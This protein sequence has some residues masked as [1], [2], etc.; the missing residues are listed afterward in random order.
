M[1]DFSL[2]PSS[3]L[4]DQETQLARLQGNVQD[5]LKPAPNAPKPI[6]PDLFANYATHQKVAMEAQLN[7][8]SYD[9]NQQISQS[10]SAAFGQDPQVTADMT[11]YAKELDIP[12]EQA[13]QNP[14]LTRRAY[15]QSLLRAKDLATNYPVVAKLMQSQNFAAQT[16]DDLDNLIYH[17]DVFSYMKRQVMSGLQQQEKGRLGMEWVMDGGGMMSPDLKAK[18][19]RIDRALDLAESEKGTLGGFLNVVGQ[20]IGTVPGTVAAGLVGSLGTP[21]AGAAASFSATL[22]QVGYTQM[23]TAYL[24][25]RARGVPHDVAVVGAFGSGLAEGLLEATGEQI[26]AAPLKAII[27]AKAAA[28][29]S[30]ALTKKTTLKALRT[31]AIDT[32]KGGAGEVGTETMQTITERMAD[33]WADTH[34]G[35]DIKKMAELEDGR[36]KL[37]DAL[38]DTIIQTVESIGPMAVFFPMLRVN[39]DISAARDARRTSNNLDQISKGKADSLLSKR[40]TSEYERMLAEQAA[41]TG[42]NTVYIDGKTAEAVLK[43]LDDESIASRAAEAGVSPEQMRAQVGNVGPVTQELEQKIPGINQR[44]KDAASTDQS[45]EI[46]LPEYIAKLGETD[47]ES[48]LRPHVRMDRNGMSL[49]ESA[50][51]KTEHVD[52]MVSKARELVAKNK[53]KATQIEEEQKQIEKM[54]FEQ[55][56]AAGTMSAANARDNATFFGALAVTSAEREGM[57]PMQWYE[58]NKLTIEGVAKTGARSTASVAIETAVEQTKREATP[59]MVQSLINIKENEVTFTDIKGD[60]VSSLGISRT[61]GDLATPG[62]L[63]VHGVVVRENARG[64]GIARALYVEAASLALK[65]GRVLQITNPE[66]TGLWDEAVA[67]GMAD[68]I[69][70]TDAEGKVTTTYTINPESLQQFIDYQNLKIME[71]TAEINARG[72]RLA[73]NDGEADTDAAERAK[74][75]DEEEIEQADIPES[76]DEVACLESTFKLAERK[77]PKGR[78]LKVEMQ[79]LLREQADAAGVNPSKPGPQTRA[80]VVRI[81]LRDALYALK[82]NQNAVGWYDI[83]TRQALA[84]MATMHPEVQTDENARFALVWAMAVTSNGLKVD[85]NFELA[86]EVYEYYKK[87]GSFPTDIGIGTAAGPINKSLELFNQLRDE[88]GIDNLRLFMQTKYTVGEIGKLWGSDLKPGGEYTRISVRGSSIL[89][90]KIGNGF[91]SNL[92]GNFDSLTMD[93]WL[94]RTWGRW[95]GTL[96]KSMPKNTA[97]ATDRLMASVAALSAESAAELSELIGIDVSKASPNELAYAVK[98]ASEDKATREELNDVDGGNELRKA[99][100]RLWTY[101][102]GQK[103]MPAG[104]EERITIRKAFAEVLSQLQAMEEYRNLT[105]ADLQAVLWYAEK[106]LYEVAHEKP[107]VVPTVEEVVVEKPKK[108]KKAKKKK[109]SESDDVEGYEDSE[110][111]DYANAAAAVARK[112]GI[113]EQVIQ[114]TLQREIENGRDRAGVRRGEDTDEGGAEGRAPTSGGFTEEQKRKFPATVAVWRL[115]R[116]AADAAPASGPYSRGD[117]GDDG[118]PRVLTEPKVFQKKQGILYTAKWK[119]SQAT[120]NAF[121]R[122]GLATPTIVELARGDMTT[123][124]HFAATIAAQKAGN[125]FGAAV[126]VYSPE[127]YAGMRLF[128]SSDNKAGFAIKTNGDIVSL[129]SEHKSK[130][131]D[132]MLHMAT[133]V[134]GKKL[135]C[136]RTVLPS[137]Y[138]KHGFRVASSIKWNDAVA[139]EGWDKSVFS[140]FNNG[141]PDVVFMVYDPDYFGEYDSSSESDSTKFGNTEADYNSAV[142]AQEIEVELIS[143]KHQAPVLKLQ[144]FAGEKSATMNKNSLER[145]K[146]MR[147]NGSG[148]LFILQE[149]GWFTGP[150]GKWRYEITDHKASWNSSALKWIESQQEAPSGASI[151]GETKFEDLFARIVS[152]QHSADRVES[153]KALKTQIRA[154]EIELQRLEVTIGDLVKE[155]MANNLETEA[156]FKRIKRCDR[157]VALNISHQALAR[158]IDE[159]SAQLSPNARGIVLLSDIL[160]HPEL[161]AAYPSLRNIAIIPISTKDVYG[162]YTPGDRTIGIN[163]NLSV[164][165]ALSTMLH[166]I[167]HGVQSIEGFAAGGSPEMVAIGS[168]MQGYLRSRGDMHRTALRRFHVMAREELQKLLADLDLPAGEKPSVGLVKSLAKQS[169]RNASFRWYQALAGE[170]EA[171]DVQRRALI[172]QQAGLLLGLGIDNGVQAWPELA[173]KFHKDTPIVIYNGKE[174]KGQPPAANIDPDYETNQLQQGLKGEFEAIGDRLRVL[175]Y[176]G[177]ADL[178]TFLHEANHY[179]AWTLFRRAAKPNAPVAVVEMANK[180]L[181][182]WGVK[183]LDTWNAMTFEEKAPKLE[184][185]AY[186]FEIYLFE[187]RAPSIEMQSVF[188][189]IKQWMREVYKNIVEKL[190]ARYKAN[191]GV[192]L[193]IMNSE[194]RQ[195][196]DRIVATDEQ[197]QRAEI[198]RK[199]VPMWQT[200]EESGMSDEQWAAYQE[201]IEDARETAHESLQADSLGTMEWLSGAR[202]RIARDLQ[203][204]HDAQR[205]EV[206]AKVIEDL[207]KSPVY[208]AINWAKGVDSDG[209]P[210]TAM[211][212][213]SIEGVRSIFPPEAGARETERS[214]ALSQEFADALKKLGTG[215][216]GILGNTGY[217]PDEV[218]AWFGF[219]NGRAMIMALV[220]AK[221]FDEAV[222][223]ETD[224]RMLAD[225]NDLVDPK[226]RERA[227]DKAL[228]NDVRSESIAI[229]WR[230][231]SLILQRLADATTDDAE[232]ART[233]AE[234]EIESLRKQHREMRAEYVKMLAEQSADPEIAKLQAERG[235]LQADLQNAE[236]QDDRAAAKDLRAQIKEINARIVDMTG[237]S[238]KK[239][240]T[241]IEDLRSRISKAEKHISGP[242][243]SVRIMVASAREAAIKA[244]D[245]QKVGDLDYQ[246]HQ[247]A[248]SRA[249]ERTIKHIKNGETQQAWDAKRTQLLQ[250]QLAKVALEVQQRIRKF[251]KGTDKFFRNDADIAKTRDIVYINAARAVITMFGIGKKRSMQGREYVEQLKNYHPEL[252]EKIRDIIDSNEAAK[253]DYRTLTVEQFEELQYT[254]EA[255]WHQAKEAKRISTAAGRVQLGVALEELKARQDEIGVPETPGMKSAL[256]KWQRIKRGWSSIKAMVRRVESWCRTTDGGKEGPFTKYIFRPVREALN[257]YREM[258]NKYVKRYLDLLQTVEMKPGNIEAHELGYT[259]GI[260]NGGLGK[261]ELLGALLHI[262]NIS[263]LRKLLLGRGWATETRN[264]KGEIEFDAS[265]WNAF[266]ARMIQEGWITKKDMD[267]CQAVW[268]LN[269]ELKPMAQR[270]HMQIFGYDFKEV[271]ARKI[272]TPFG[273]YRGGYVPAKPDPLVSRDAVKNAKLEAMQND[274]RQSMPAAPSGWR[275]TR[276]EA[277]L[278]PL[279]LDVR[280]MAKHIDEVIRFSMVQPAIRDVTKILK[281]DGFKDGMDAMDPMAIEEML[282]PWLNRAARQISEEP[283]MSGYIDQFWRTVRRNVGID[284]MFLNVSNALQQIT[285]LAITGTRV[286]GTYIKA[287]FASYLGKPRQMADDVAELSP[288]MRDRMENQMMDMQQQLDDIL[289]NPSKWDKVTAYGRKRAYILQSQMQN[290]VD[291]VSWNAAY[292]QYVAESDNVDAQAVQR[293]AIAHADAVV[294]ETQSSLAPED[295]AAYEAGTPFMRTLTQ[296]S[297]Y[298]NMLANLNAGAFINIIRDMGGVSPNVSR[299]LHQYLLGFAAPMILSEAIARSFAGKWADDDDDGYSDEMMDWL[300]GSQARGIFA[301]VPG[302]GQGMQAVANSFNDLPYDDRLTTSPSIAALES[303]TVGVVRAV[304]NLWDEDKSVTGKNIRDVITGL[305]V[306]FGVPLSA[307]GKPITYGYDISTG[308]T[309]PTG[310]V[311]YGRGL[312]TGI[313][314]EASLGK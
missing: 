303:S 242:I 284:R 134:G 10:V 231:L 203:K 78:D 297:N 291:V 217:H 68:V 113:P 87:N 177:D 218:A 120:R 290:I 70:S 247:V 124:K 244:I 102:D 39:H 123:A 167:A 101:L 81:A 179:F 208:R 254:I 236:A 229:E 31:F 150:D 288:F 304:R 265:R 20:A 169:I 82:Q 11:K 34:S 100:N 204:K 23:G 41:R 183:D 114:E 185:L 307:F 14:D 313:S 65:E 71:R 267:F 19:D 268:D 21:A 25:M 153:D 105:M 264:A 220:E 178:S 184:A 187:G 138:A 295:I 148:N 116:A 171:R 149:T 107:A 40:N 12:V 223:E 239:M 250:N 233:K 30:G 103:E 170:M 278:R 199:M 198:I 280:L 91:F 62:S 157:I 92:Y 128:I 251:I 258:R 285:G 15:E 186:N 202:S 246:R 249:A 108:A 309:N 238:L 234:A 44:I 47:V 160:E 63:N 110:A 27:A 59:T 115:R 299:L 145:A 61:E 161:F 136:F 24:E 135:D 58:E 211:R 224:R 90:P 22:A 213:I 245:Q 18:I 83:K 95:T 162:Y 226:A 50:V 121:R 53:E 66:L 194:L 144:Q 190:N 146:Q 140:K 207:K 32:L 97:L 274:F 8:S 255:L 154:K 283:G 192:D 166:E 80:Y 222:K 248:E 271:E 302:F 151:P 197:I 46:P 308:R 6:A 118:S 188:R 201:K 182:W 230:H 195:V 28:K 84:I 306:A 130:M 286:K 132:A 191:F 79:R 77:F 48:R 189:R 214:I 125:R 241:E 119:P 26:I 277:Y 200:K 60:L 1:S 219:E 292:N 196:F 279:S 85:K 143:N 126:Y 141:E 43:Q 273:E 158:E 232:R 147:A 75:D 181:K 133:Q 38:A 261:A 256:T 253:K 67:S 296:F 35:F 42:S 55:L 7:P 142:N 173:M 314:S 131:A 212:R 4:V 266:F 109:K 175:L 243:T 72:S 262:G 257:R 301:M 49:H 89:G 2:I 139:P 111:P 99:G 276:Q 137:I 73:Q 106:R 263:N 152:K 205:A 156:V 13:L 155:N 210:D 269:E 168:K 270:A 294:R 56:K 94:I 193:P 228:H 52:E 93:R 227:I 76:V 74:G 5:P 216:H 180:I 16:R 117:A 9:I 29:V 287:S 252:Y 127:E 122:A 176:Q 209:I 310:F 281:D 69:T 112:A 215:R 163:S 17:D 289:L 172:K 206:E 221:E 298:F 235:S 174:S 159:L 272:S 165:E 3:P 54:V 57:S 282:L 45:V 311:D 300:L 37:A 164:G 275:H 129:F 240:Q 260:G 237:G 259:F 86:A 98:K 51:Y 96:I 88:V 305:S 64:Q 225:H 36:Q 312:I 104:P 293:D 33:I